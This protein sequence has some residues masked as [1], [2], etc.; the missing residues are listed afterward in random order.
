MK[1]TRIIG[2]AALALGSLLGT[3][4]AAQTDTIP[5]AEK[6]LTLKLGAFLPTNGTV[7]KA[8]GNTWFSA[9]AEY[10]FSPLAEEPG[11]TP[12]VYVDYAGASKHGLAVNYIG[13]GPGARYYL[14]P[15]GAGTTPIYI[16]GGIGGYFL[17]AS[18]D[19]SS[20]NKTKFGFKV[21][22][23]IEFQ[24]QYLVEV[25]YTNAGSDSGTRFD[26]VGLQV[27]AR[28]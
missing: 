25:N 16:G 18:G 27:G 28:F 9:G 3:G 2:A 4:A 12:L 14:T 15:P 22:A 23:G 10:A 20:L 26:G 19:G 24:Q 5:A 6:P 21:D 7:K 17:H 8:V 1:K 13:I 11:L